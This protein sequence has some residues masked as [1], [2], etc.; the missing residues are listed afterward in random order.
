MSLRVDNHV[1]T[2]HSGHSAP[3]ADV[4][5]MRRAAEAG[6]LT[7]SLRE[8]APLPEGYAF[9]QTAGPS[10]EFPP[11]SKAVGLA[12]DDGSLEAFLEEVRQAG[13]SLGFEVDILGGRLAETERLV[14]ELRRRTEAAGVTI[15]ALNCSHHAMHD[16]PWDFTPQT[17]LA[18]VATCG[19]AARFTRQYFGEIREAVGTGLFQGVSHIEGPLKFEAGSPSGPVGVVWQEEMARTLETLARHDVALE[20]NTGGLATWGRPH[21][22]REHLAL[23]VRLGLKLVVGSDAHDPDQVG[24]GFAEAEQVLRQAGVAEVWTFKAGRAVPISTS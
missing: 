9:R 20:Y 4:G 6:G 21:L 12:L 19:G 8:H 24:R 7:L 5:T 17:L 3:G 18:A 2:Q 14:A 13:V 23:A 10:R 15:D 11:V 1:H 16:S 22:S